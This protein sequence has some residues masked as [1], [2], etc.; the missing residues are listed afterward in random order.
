MTYARRLFGYL[1]LAAALA[2]VALVA[3][4]AASAGGLDD[5]VPRDTS[6][7]PISDYRLSFNNGAG[8]FGAVFTP[9]KTVP[10]AFAYVMFI[11]FIGF[12]WMGLLALNILL[13]ADWMS[14]LVRTIDA[15]ANRLY[16]DLGKEYIISIIALL[17]IATVG[18][19]YLR[20]QW[21]RAWH[22]I[23]VTFIV[24][25]VGSAIAFPVAE[26]AKMLGIG[27]DAAVDSG[28]R[29]VGGEGMASKVDPANKDSA[30]NP[31]G[32]LVDEWVR[33]PVQRWT[34]GQDLDSI[35]PACRD[36][37]T[38]RVKAG[39]ADKI[40]DAPIDCLG[41]VAGKAMHDYA[42][43]PANSSVDSILL[44]LFAI[45]LCVGL[46]TVVVLV[47][48]TAVMALIH[49]GLIKVG[50]IGA[51]TEMGQNFLVRN[52]IDAPV[53][54]MF[55]FLGLLG[56]YVAA[57]V[58]KILAQTIPSS[59]AGMGLLIL[60]VA[61]VGVGAKK[62]LGNLKSR[63]DAAARRIVSGSGAGAGS[64]SA[65]TR[66]QSA[67]RKALAVA[68][69]T[70]FA[71]KRASRKVRAA[72]A[73]AMSAP[74]AAVSKIR[75]AASKAG[76][77][78]AAGAAGAASAGGVAAGAVAAGGGG[79]YAGGG[80][81][82]S[83][84]FG[85][86]GAAASAR[87]AATQYRRSRHIVVMAG[88]TPRVAGRG[89]PS[90]QMAGAMAGGGYTGGPG[91]RTGGGVPQPAASRAASGGNAPARGSGGASSAGSQASA[92]QTARRSSPTQGGSALR[93]GGAGGGAR[94]VA[95][96]FRGNKKQ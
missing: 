33:K 4:P 73:P 65:L 83:S 20:N 53:G 44:P 14:P 71:A 38:N 7:V 49:A 24:V 5:I 23:A 47:L 92:P 86:R 96:G 16:Q 6:G 28:Q 48:G 78:G 87:A 56:V 55:F 8:F 50:L 34:F 45:I 12:S 68:A 66:P 80:G 17:L 70:G 46:W 37:W 88:N 93:G 54:G 62:A 9:D 51:S 85:G 63:R 1:G 94:G 57:D 25:I 26:A 81:A 42:M 11:V 10:S 82:G 35:S 31:T 69:A 41:P 43:N 91:P 18:M 19:Y 39:D 21:N 79:Q 27:R 84:G 30:S 60:L 52:G 90:R 22:H 74:S 58:S 59:T 36:A 29:V 3:A 61:S 64:S 32:V 89:N 72:A 95:R 13:I 2:A 40:K 67:G 76:K 77:V 15:T 75:S